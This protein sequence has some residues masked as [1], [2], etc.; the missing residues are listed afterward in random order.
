LT[1]GDT[2][3]A[4]S[5]GNT[6]VVTDTLSGKVGGIEIVGVFENNSIAANSHILTLGT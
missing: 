1:T 2:Y 5:G 6:L 4:D 3:T